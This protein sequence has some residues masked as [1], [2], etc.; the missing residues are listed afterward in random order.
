MKKV[1]TIILTIVVICSYFIGCTKCINTETYADQVKIVDTHFVNGR[2][3]PIFNGKSQ[4]L[5][6]IPA[7]YQVIV[8]Y[9][10]AEY[11]V[12]GKDIYDKYKDRIGSTVN[13]T[14]KKKNYKDGAVKYSIIKIE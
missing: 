12:N 2:W 7:T 3:Q 9:D 14:I 4:T 11:T 5:I 6:Y 10:D 1:I 8:S 13:A